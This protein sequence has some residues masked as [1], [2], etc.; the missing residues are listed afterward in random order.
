MKISANMIIWEKPEPF[1]IYVL[2]SIRWVDELI[3]VDTARGENENL[4]KI[5][6]EQYNPESD[7][8][9]G[10]IVLDDRELK[11]KIVSYFKHKEKFDFASARNLA[12]EHSSKDWCWKVDADE[13]YYESF[14]KTLK[15][16]LKGGLDAYEVEFYH[17]MLDVF[18]YQY[19]Q[20]T[21]VLFRN[22][23]RIKWVGKVHEKLKGIESRKKLKDRFCHF[24][25]AK[26]QEETFERW[27][28]Y[29]DLEGKSDWYKGQDPS[30]ILDDRAGVCKPFTG[31][32]P[33]VMQ[34]Y[35]KTA[36]RV[37]FGSELSNKVAKFGIVLVGYFNQAQTIKER[38]EVISKTAN[39]PL[40]LVIVVSAFNKGGKD[41]VKKLDHEIVHFEGYQKYVECLNAGIKQLIK[42]KQVRWIGN[43]FRGDVV[44]FV[45]D[46][47]KEDIGLIKLRGN[48][49]IFPVDVVERLGLFNENYDKRESIKLFEDKVKLNNLIVK[50]E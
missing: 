37:I 45:K 30:H 18:N 35:I 15:E 20:S 47:G 8:T 25:Y 33:S 32:Y 1:L 11:F 9:S 28:R 7:I 13:V 49:I 21:E 10:V 26:P 27:Q 31:Q 16:K 5:F 50:N 19:I 14:E 44:D 36:P 42:D 43:V 22:I 46:F 34:D 12:K 48:Q 4:K 6:G 40:K 38:V 17:F 39:F 3:I 29:V 24:G 41:E 23:D 2:R